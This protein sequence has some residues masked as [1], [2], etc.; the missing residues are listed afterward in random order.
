[1]KKFSVLGVIALATLSAQGYAQ[2]N[3]PLRL[4]QTIP[5]PNERF[6]PVELDSSVKQRRS[7]VA[8]TRVDFQLVAVF[9]SL[10]V[11]GMES[12]VSL[13]GRRRVIN[14]ITSTKDL[15]KVGQTPPEVADRDRGESGAARLCRQCFQRRRSSQWIGLVSRAFLRAHRIYRDLA[16]L[17]C[18]DGLLE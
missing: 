8:L 5:M 12:P 6:R 3:V 17:R 4:I 16:P 11:H 7:I 9:F 14:Q 13:R 1:M 18:P 15:L 10:D 2:G